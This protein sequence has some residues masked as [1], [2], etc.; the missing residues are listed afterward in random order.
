MSSQLNSFPEDFFFGGGEGKAVFQE[1]KGRERK[2]IVLW[3]DDQHLND[4]VLSEAK[5][6]MERQY[7]TRSKRRQKTGRT[8]QVVPSSTSQSENRTLRK[9]KQIEDHC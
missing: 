3:E 1:T 9:P 2:K 5:D 7:R 4:R 6:K 8:S